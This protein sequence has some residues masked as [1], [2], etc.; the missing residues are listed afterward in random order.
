MEA[1]IRQAK[2]QYDLTPINELFNNF[3]T[4]EQLREELVELAFDYASK[5]E[6]GESK[7]FKSN[8]GTIYVVYDV[9]RN[10]K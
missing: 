2:K 8:M 10:V 3:I 6:D 4:P 5:V 7:L 1:N 9:L